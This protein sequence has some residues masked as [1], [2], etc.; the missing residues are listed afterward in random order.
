MQMVLKELSERQLNFFFCWVLRII[1]SAIWHITFF[2]VTEYRPQTTLSAF[3]T[4]QSAPIWSKSV[5]KTLKLQVFTSAKD[6]IFL[7]TR[8]SVPFSKHSC[9]HLRLRNSIKIHILKKKSLLQKAH[10]TEVFL[11]DE[12][13]CVNIF[14][15]EWE[16]SSFVH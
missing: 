7:L 13:V 15:W 14:T 9:L 1:D 8:M 11:T 3:V 4:A 16:I 2:S 10:D 12:D 6:H 5:S